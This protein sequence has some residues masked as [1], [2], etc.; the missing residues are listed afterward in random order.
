MV[1]FVLV[2]SLVLYLGYFGTNVQESWNS[3]VNDHLPSGKVYFNWDHG[4]RHDNILLA[5]HDSRIYLGPFLKSKASQSRIAFHCKEGDIYLDIDHRDVVFKSS[6]VMEPNL[7]AASLGIIKY[8]GL[9]CEWEAYP[10]IIVRYDHGQSP[11]YFIVRDKWK[12]IKLP[13][14]NVI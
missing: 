13:K 12:S 14:Q 2:A 1:I 5:D 8:F 3:H 6:V 9:N 11:Q 4:R 10:D 7:I